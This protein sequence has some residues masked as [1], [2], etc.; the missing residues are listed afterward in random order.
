MIEVKLIR[1]EFYGHKIPMPKHDRDVGVDLRACIEYGTLL[2]PNE[3]RLFPSGIAISI[4]PE[5]RI[6]GMV[7]PRSG[8]GSKNG[9]VLGNLTG[10]IDP[11]YTGEIQL[12]LW[13]R[14]GKPVDIE[15][16]MRVAQLIIM[17]YMVWHEGSARQVEHFAHETERGDQGF[18]ST[19]SD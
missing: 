10:I 6:F 12:S 2:M 4:R 14:T 8:L 1:P 17:P 16:G 7:V 9:V 15:P 13:N 11:T 19:G 5:V 3:S 18:G